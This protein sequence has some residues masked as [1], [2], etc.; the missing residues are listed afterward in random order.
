MNYYNSETLLE[1]QQEIEKL[2]EQNAAM[3]AQVEALW[4]EI[5]GA[6]DWF[7][8]YWPE[9]NKAQ[10]DRIKQ[11]DGVAKSTPA[12]CLAQVRADAGR[13]GF[14]TGANSM[15]LAFQYGGT[16]NTEDK[17]NQYHASILAGKE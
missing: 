10:C 3:S 9:L 11:M 5:Q 1:Q 6:A 4:R 15:K 16:Y 8:A 13:A 17:A 12:A 7:S 2:K 14:V